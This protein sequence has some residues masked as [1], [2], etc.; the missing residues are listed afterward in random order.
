VLMDVPTRLRLS[1]QSI[2]SSAIVGD[3]KVVVFFVFVVVIVQHV[4]YLL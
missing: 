3:V 1:A 2:K 4:M